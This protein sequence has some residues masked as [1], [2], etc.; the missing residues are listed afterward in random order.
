MVAGREADR[1]VPA[2]VIDQEDGHGVAG[3]SGAG[4]SRTAADIREPGVAAQA[5]RQTVDARTEPGALVSHFVETFPWLSVDALLLAE[6]TVFDTQRP[7]R[8]TGEKRLQ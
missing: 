7:H 3:C 2:I 8:F 4:S 5:S 6:T 1:D